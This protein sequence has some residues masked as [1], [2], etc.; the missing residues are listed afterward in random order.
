VA[1][2]GTI[3]VTEIVGVASVEVSDTVSDVS[4]TVDVASVLHERP[5]LTTT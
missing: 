1:G 2:A 4:E 5:G 3:T